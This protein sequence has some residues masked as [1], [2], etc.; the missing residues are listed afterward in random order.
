MLSGSVSEH[1][2]YILHVKDAK[3]VFRAWLHY[4]G[5]PKLWCIHSIPL[6][7][8]I[9]RSVSEHFANLCH[10]WDA[11]LVFQP[12]CTIS[13]Y[14]SC[15]A[16]ILLHWTRNDVWEC[17]RAFHYPSDVKD[18]N[19]VFRF[20]MHYFGVPMLRCMHSPPLEPKWYLGVLRSVSPIFGT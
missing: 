15:E 1:F 17:F 10:V 9:F 7:K 5:V 12:E 8:M 2:A 20:W 13:G 4:F 19:L 11:K 14:R 6:D 3:L 16:S 18:A